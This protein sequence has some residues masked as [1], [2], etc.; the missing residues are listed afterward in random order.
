MVSGVKTNVANSFPVK[1]YPNTFR[2][3]VPD[4]ISVKSLTVWFSEG[5]FK[6]QIPLGLNV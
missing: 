2:K 4:M 6:K 3:K 1:S 5:A